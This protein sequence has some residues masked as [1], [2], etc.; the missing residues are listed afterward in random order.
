MGQTLKKWCT[1]LE[2]L[3]GNVGIKRNWKNTREIIKIHTKIKLDH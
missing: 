1:G 3:D 2:N